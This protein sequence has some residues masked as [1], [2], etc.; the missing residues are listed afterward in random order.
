MSRHNQRPSRRLALI[1]CSSLALTLSAAP[2]YAFRPFEGTDAQVAPPRAFELEPMGYERMGDAHLL[3]GPEWA[4]NYGF[5]A[6]SEFTFEGKRLWLTNAEPGERVGT[7][8]DIGLAVKKVLRSGVL[9][10]KPGPSLAMEVEA[11][12]PTSTERGAGLSGAIIATQGVGITTLHFNGEIAR[13]REHEFGRAA[14]LIV[15]LEPKGWKLTPAIEVSV[16]REG[17]A[18]TDQGVLGALLWEAAPSLTI[19]GA[20]RYSSNAE[21]D[22]ELLWGFTWKKHIK[23]GPKV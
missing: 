1:V 20:V 2:A 8:E 6:G 18:P 21:H 11:Q 9:Q 17:N 5:G 15:Q 14:S 12:L 19:D 13:N 10:E 23:N 3:V 7:F 22:V 16:D 4:M